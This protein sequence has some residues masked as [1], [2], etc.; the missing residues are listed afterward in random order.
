MVFERRPEMIPHYAAGV[1]SYYLSPE[2][3]R[4]GAAANRAN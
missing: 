2:V 4:H 1:R 3:T